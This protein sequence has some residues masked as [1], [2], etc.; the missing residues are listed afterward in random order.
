MSDRPAGHSEIC[1]QEPHH[2]TSRKPRSRRCDWTLPRLSGGSVYKL[3]PRSRKRR[4]TLTPVQGPSDPQERG[5]Q[6]TARRTCPDGL[7][8]SSACCAYA[9]S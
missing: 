6:L 5:K 9:L 1:E 2:Q 7:G 3:Q 4:V 8:W